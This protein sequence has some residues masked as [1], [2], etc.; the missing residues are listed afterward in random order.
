MS[1]IEA[2]RIDR[3]GRVL[4]HLR[5]H[6]TDQ[7]P[8][9]ATISPREY[10]DPELAGRERKL[11]FGKVPSI[12][13]HGSELP[14]PNDFIALQMPRNKLI[15]MRQED[16]SVKAFVNACRH[17]G[18]QLVEE[19]T[20]RCHLFSCPY[21]RWSYNTDGSL[22][23]ITR[24]ATVGELD[25]SRLGLI[26]VPAEERHGLIW[27]IDSSD[28]TIDVADWLGDE[29]DRILAG[30]DLDQLVCYRAES[31][32]EHVNW[33]IMQDAFLDGYHI[34]YAHP[35]TAGKYIHTN[36]SV[37][38]DFG[39]HCRWLKPRKSIDRWI[40]ED[41]ADGRL[42]R[43][44]IE[45]Q[46]VAPNTTLL[47]HHDHFQILSFR[48]HPR[49][50]RRSVM[51][52]RVIVPSPEASQLEASAWQELWDKNWDILIRVL[53]GED[54]PLLRGTQQAVENSDT[55]DLTL[56]RNEISNHIFRR[57]TQRLLAADGESPT[58]I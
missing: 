15:V 29:M 56:C 46:F 47:H 48:P 19:A 52:M 37:V 33:K 2:N 51:D 8:T 32:E 57:E 10:T 41:P 31:F 14:E 40:D 9:T 18:G 6:T 11:I 17:R 1:A 5:N 12:V 27:V 21:H 22:R 54:F 53:T 20:G 30:Y 42:D 58:K 23:A 28:A 45:T 7:Y 38:E 34:Q 35:N 39:R 49:E 26:E 55:G 16:G 4:D 13:A 24:E 44:L 25:H 43:H 50:P 36:I 3:I